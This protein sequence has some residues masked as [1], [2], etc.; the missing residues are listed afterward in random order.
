MFFILSSP[1]LIFWGRA[2][3][4]AR[5]GLVILL[6]AFLTV[7]LI[8]VGWRSAVQAWLDVRIRAFR[9]LSAVLTHPLAAI[10]TPA[11]IVTALAY[12]VFHSLIS[13]CDFLGAGV[14]ARPGCSF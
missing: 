3:V 4:C 8:C 6:L 2:C 10:E 12:F 7:G 14:C 11:V 5:P 9:G 1:S 13:L